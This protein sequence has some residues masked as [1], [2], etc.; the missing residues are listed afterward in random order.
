MGDRNMDNIKYNISE[1]LELPKD[2][3][4]DLAKITVIGNM[5]VYISNHK[6][7]IE[8]SLDTI[9]INTNDGIIKITGENLRIK[10]IMAEEIIVLGKIEKIE[11]L[12]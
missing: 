5:Q 9:R 12:D 6:G 11:L 4:M 1:L 7:I 8:Y 3:I 10:T 2:I